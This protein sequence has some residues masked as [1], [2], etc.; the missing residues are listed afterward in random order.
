M[1]GIVVEALMLR[2]RLSNSGTSLVWKVAYYGLAAAGALCLWLLNESPDTGSSSVSR[3]KVLQHLSVL[4]AEIEAGTLVETD[5]SNYKLL[6]SASQT[7]GNLLDQLL[8]SDPERQRRHGDGFDP[9]ILPE[10]RNQTEWT[11]W[12]NAALQE[13]EVDFWLNLAGHPSLTGVENLPE[14]YSRLS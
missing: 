8:Q 11:P 14:N 6:M 10:M 9:S 7:I 13:F 5:D 3:S 1:F 4:V 2:N 12:D